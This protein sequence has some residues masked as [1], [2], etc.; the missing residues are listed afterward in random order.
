MQTRV[1]VQKLQEHRAD[2]FHRDRRFPARGSSCIVTPKHSPTAALKRLT[3]AIVNHGRQRAWR[4]AIDLLRTSKRRQMQP[5]VIT[6]NATISACEKGQQWLPVWGLLGQ[7]RT[8]NNTL[9]GTT[10]MISV[11]AL[12]LPT[13][14]SD[15]LSCKTIFEISSHSRCL[16][17]GRYPL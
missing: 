17:Q 1:G 11:Q 9:S 7:M 14:E 2:Q 10:Y 4:Q 5:D 3:T 8:G 12:L 16:V 6:Y 13:S 15:L